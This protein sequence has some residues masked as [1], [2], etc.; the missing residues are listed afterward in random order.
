MPG[1]PSNVLGNFVRCCYGSKDAGTIWEAFYV[2]ALTSTGFLQG[3]SSPCA[4]W[5]PTLEISVVV[6]GDDFTALGTDSALDTYE[7]EL[8]K[9]FDLKLRGRLGEE[10]QDLKED[11]GPESYLEGDSHRPQ[12]RS[13]SAAC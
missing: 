1:L 12:I 11:R 6:H 9:K 4:F 8:L 10:E 7:S 13:G 2:D 3:K 5:H